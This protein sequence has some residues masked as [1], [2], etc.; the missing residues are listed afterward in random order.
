MTQ[1]KSSATLL[2]RQSILSQLKSNLIAYDDDDDE[3]D[4]AETESNALYIIVING[5][6]QNITIRWLFELMQKEQH[7]GGGGFKLKRIVNDDK[8]ADE[9]NDIIIE[10]RASNARINNAAD[11]M[12][13]KQWSEGESVVR[14]FRVNDLNRDSDKC[15]TTSEKQRVLLHEIE[16]LHSNE[17]GVLFGYPQ[18]KLYP[19]QSICKFITNT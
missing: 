3:D 5:E 8:N 9:D 12:Q 19:G 11:A 14:V 15:L 10:V 18:V 1:R 2:E 6:A 7:E 13:L 17:K 16:S 4:D